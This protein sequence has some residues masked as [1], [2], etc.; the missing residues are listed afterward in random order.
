MPKTRWR[1]ALLMFLWF[2]LA[3]GFFIWRHAEPLVWCDSVVV[4]ENLFE[5]T[6]PLL[7][8]SP[9]AITRIVQESFAT[10][11]P[12]GYR[13]LSQVIL[14][15]GVALF[16]EPTFVPDMWFAAG[17]FVISSMALTFFFVAR[18]FLQSDTTTLLALFLFLFSTPI[19]TGA[20]NM[21]CGFQA[22]VP[23]IICLGLLFYW[24]FIEDSENKI[25]NG[26]IFSLILIC[27]PWFREVVGLLPLLII[28]LEA[29][30]TRRPTL[31]M[32]FAGV[33]FVHAIYPT[34]LVKW[35]IFPE[36]EMRPVF[37]MGHLGVQSSVASQ[38]SEP[39]V[40]RLLSDISVRAAPLHFLTLYPPLLFVLSV[41]AVSL[42][43]F[44]PNPS[45]PG[46]R[47]SANQQHDQT[48]WSKISMESLASLIFLLGIPIIGFTVQIEIFGV[49]WVALVALWVCFGLVLLS[50]KVDAFLGWWFLLF[51]IPFLKL[52]TEQVH[53]A[54]CLLPASIILVSSLERM[55]WAVQKLTDPWKFVRLAFFLT[56]LVIIADHSL[57]PIN[58]YRV[59][60]A[61]ND[62]IVRMAHWFRSNAAPG[63]IV[64]TN[65]LHGED[66]RFF[67]GGHVKTYWTLEEGIPRKS[68]ALAEPKQLE[69][70]LNS[71]S[72]K[73]DV[74]FL[75]VTYDYPPDKVDYHAHRYLRDESVDTERIGH[76]HTTRSLYPFFDP[77]KAWVS[78]PYISFLG[79]PDL[80]NDFYRGPAQDGKKFF[81]EV[82]A[83][84][85]VHKVVGKLVRSSNSSGP[86]KL[87]REGYRGFNIIVTNGQF[88][89]IPQGEGS[90]ELQRL[91]NKI[92][93]KSFVAD[94]YDEIT[95]QIDNALDQ[96]SKGGES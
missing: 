83:E 56:L 63:S 30:R 94:D 64:I 6:R 53:L 73:R 46:Q 70:L 74:Y 71:V 96:R 42:P 5:E 91:Q 4:A 32:A 12:E 13:P 35:L 39:I 86:V 90:F 24:R 3:G 40:Y 25:W 51:F 95:R 27:G 82:Y 49:I 11:K 62:G 59:V 85:H 81:R 19:V 52:F 23:L 44:N 8:G 57:N 93:S 47:S 67:S 7:W 36:L 18:R 72:G 45:P 21:V 29:Q 28:F 58:S 38:A 16:S 65:A 41:I 2:A 14:W 31:L 37:S 54:Y 78:R 60:H 34:A 92:Y 79:P 69:N 17:G 15:T 66:I 9:D 33:C 80:E 50:L 43:L 1:T 68:D 87:Y 84:Y 20:W 88:F 48:R 26:L 77:L 76:V 61:I 22:I 89:A 55:R 10:L 75:N